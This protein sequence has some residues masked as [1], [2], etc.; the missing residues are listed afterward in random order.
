MCEHEFVL[1]INCG[2]NVCQGCG[3]HAHLSFEDGSITQELARCWCGWS[4]HGYN[5]RSEL[6]EMGETLAWD[7]DDY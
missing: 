2:A 6:V 5:G 1:V 3:L 4:A 7:E